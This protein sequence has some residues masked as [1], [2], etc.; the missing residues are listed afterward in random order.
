MIGKIKEQKKKKILT[1][2]SREMTVETMMAVDGSAAGDS[3]SGLITSPFSF[4]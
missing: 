3:G 2:T 1:H 4:S